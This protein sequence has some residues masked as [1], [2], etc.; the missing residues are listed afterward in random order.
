MSG[1]RA[2]L[3]DH[4]PGVQFA[5]PVNLLNDLDSV[6]FRNVGRVK[7]LDER[8]QLGSPKS[9]QRSVF[10]QGPSLFAKPFLRI[11]RDEL[12]GTGVNS[13]AFVCHHNRTDF[14]V[15]ADHHRV[16]PFADHDA[17]LGPQ[18]FDGNRQGQDLRK[19]LHGVF[20][21][22]WWDIGHNVRR[23]D[24]L[25]FEVMKCYSDGL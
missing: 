10:L 5:K 16:G 8:L 24:C 14:D 20:A 1:G 2:A 7:C 17:G 9:V 19:K 15:A 3:F 23:I 25:C 4:Q 11:D 12:S 22:L 13:D 6:F 21:V 18:I